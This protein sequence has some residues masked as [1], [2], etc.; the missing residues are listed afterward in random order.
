M[1]SVLGT[2]YVA[3]VQIK[4]EISDKIRQPS[5]S[6]RWCLVALVPGALAAGLLAITSGGSLAA[7]SCAF[8]KVG[9]TAPESAGMKCGGSSR[10]API[11]G[12]AIAI[13]RGSPTA[14]ALTPRFG[15]IRGLAGTLTATVFVS[16]IHRLAGDVDAPWPNARSA[17]ARRHAKTQYHVYQIYFHNRRTDKVDAYKYGIT[18]RGGERIQR[19][20]PR[21]RRD[22]RTHTNRC[23]GRWVRRDVTG[24]HRARV[25]ETMYCVRYQLRVGR[26]PYGMPRCI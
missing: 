3:R 17:T 12:G 11:A 15:S 20:L 16:Q 10:G 23:N 8:Y 25:I 18:R 5:R 9:E 24:W 7:A 4:D 13:P 26:R 19:Q 22:P 1:R 2:T 14:G 21:C 6:P